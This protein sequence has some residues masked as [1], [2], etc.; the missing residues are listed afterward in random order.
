MKY[1]Q[2][3]W[4]TVKYREDTFDVHLSNGIQSIS[5]IRPIDS[6]INIAP[7][8]NMDAMKSIQ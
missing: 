8:L 7:M 1:K 6:E 3:T 2:S 4:I 5:E